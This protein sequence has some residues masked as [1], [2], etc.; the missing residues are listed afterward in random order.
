MLEKLKSGFSSFVKRT[1]TE[2][3]LD[4]AIEDLRLL[5]ISN[6]VALDTSDEICNQIL[7]S[8]KGEQLSRFT[9][10]KKVLIETLTKVITEILTPDNEIDLLTEIRKK[11]KSEPYVIVF[12][13]VNGTG[14]TTTMAKIAHFLKING[15]SIVAAAADT[16]RA[17]AIEQLSYHMEKVGIRVI[18]HDYK[19][20]P[21]S[22][23]YDAIEHAK[24]KNINV[25]LI[26]TAGRQVSDFNLMR[27]LQ[28]ICRV[29][30]PD[31]IV[32]VGDSLAGNDALNQAREFKKNVG[33]DANILTKL[34]A[35]ANGGAALSIS[36][37]T[38]KPIL[39]IGVGQSIEDLKPFDREFFISKILDGI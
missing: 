32:F 4:N 5:L 19:S 3:K 2:K 10:I 20:D 26:D 7:E 15:F 8:F 24:A 25:V 39:F 13:G 21:A 27:E 35:D 23:A 33:I 17:A 14:K 29:A 12:L 16:F 31:L 30:Q 28:K 18:K 11:K 34:D 36:Y 1:L 37:E 6:D 38:N 22:V 9:S